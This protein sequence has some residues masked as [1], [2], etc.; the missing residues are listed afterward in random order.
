MA[1]GTSSCDKKRANG[2]MDKEECE[3]EATDEV[4]VTGSLQI[5]IKK[6]HLIVSSV[7]PPF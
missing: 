4:F 5:L 2:A 6:L 7:L 3:V 1:C